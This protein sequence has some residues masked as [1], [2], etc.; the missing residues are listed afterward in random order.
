MFVKHWEIKWYADF[1][2]TRGGF[3]E[4]VVQPTSFQ[5]AV[6][7]EVW[8]GVGLHSPKGYILQ[9]HNFQDIAYNMAIAFAPGTKSPATHH[10]L[11]DLRKMYQ[12]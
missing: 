8:D 10:S 12:I 2:P 1:Q 5:I 4:H 6:E 3:K 11:D 7:T 9:K